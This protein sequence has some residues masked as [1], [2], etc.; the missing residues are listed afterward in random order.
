MPAV[1][2][3][4]LRLFRFILWCLKGLWGGDLKSKHA[5]RDAVS[6][7]FVSSF[8]VRLSLAKTST[9]GG[10]DPLQGPGW[11]RGSECL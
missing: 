10:C 5:S 6:K 11:N 7:V 8:R 3:K 4:A 2:F 1:E 9:E